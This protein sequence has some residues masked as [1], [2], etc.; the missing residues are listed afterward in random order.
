MLIKS[1][2]FNGRQAWRLSNGQMDLVTLAGGGHIAGVFLK[3]G[4]DINPYWQPGW[5][6]IEPW[7]YRPAM[8]GKYGASLL[9]GIA[10]HSIC[11][12]V[13]GGPSPDEERAGGPGCHGEAPIVRWRVLGRQCSARRLA[14]TYGCDLPVARMALRRTLTMRAGSCVVGVRE[15]VEN[16]ARCDTPF[17]MCQHVSFSAPFIEPG[18]TV[19]DMAGGRAHTFP[20]A[21]G[22]PQR[23]KPDT[24][25]TWPAG[26]GVKGRVDLR[27]MGRGRN[28]DFYAVLMDSRRAQVWFSAMNPRQGLMV[29]YAWRPEDYPWTGVWE[30]N[31][32]RAAAPW[33]GREV[34]RGMEFANAPFPLSLRDAVNLGRFQGRPAFRWL[35]ARGRAVFEYAILAR[36]VAPEV[37]GVADVQTDG[38]EAEV[39]FA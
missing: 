19:F 29:A 32:A 27:T 38:A 16:L 25:F 11:L 34:A 36:R 8:A 10:G 9:A 15:V 28:S 6:T 4:P 7:Q 12:G 30:E 21:F 31:R 18:V 3:G 39:K 23:L 13:F 5:R 33:L 17:T 20:G 1:E 37:R 26:P 24:A 35:P 14:F 2:K 22:K